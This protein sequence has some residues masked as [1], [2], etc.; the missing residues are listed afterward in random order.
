MALFTV[1]VPLAL[2]AGN[3]LLQHRAGKNAQDEDEKRMKQQQLL[4]AFGGGGGG[5]V[6]QAP[7]PGVLGALGSVLSI[8]SNLIGKALQNKY[9]GG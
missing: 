7:E 6:P 1:G 9:G 4:A 8:N 5:F 3:M 2:Q